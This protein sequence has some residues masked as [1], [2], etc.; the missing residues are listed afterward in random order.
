MPVNAKYRNQV[1]L[2]EAIAKFVQ[3]KDRNKESYNQQEK[4]FLRRYTG[5]GGQKG[6]SGEGILYEFYTPD[7]ICDLMYNL[8]NSHGYDGGN[9]LEPSCA[10]GELIRP[11]K[12]YSK[13][14]GF[15][16]NPVSR[17]I[18]EILYPGATIHEGYFERAM[19]EPPRYTTAIKKSVTWLPQYPFSLVIGNPPYGKYKNMYSSYFDKKLFQQI[20]IFF[21]Y[22]GLRMLKSGGLLVYIISSNFLR[23]GDKYN[24]AKEKIGEIAELVDAYRLPS[25]FQ[26]SEVPTDIIVLRKK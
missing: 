18:A 15:E 23:N 13:V 2:N 17:R 20:E 14:V 19:L 6:Q 16:I 22:Q 10:T 26:Y 1:E 24:Y 21:V 12:D 25:V 4:E 5:S 9:I 11:A 3:E 7:Y 8:A